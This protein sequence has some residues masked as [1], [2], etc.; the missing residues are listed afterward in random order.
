[1]YEILGKQVVG[2]DIKRI[3]IKAPAIVKNGKLGQFVVIMP[4]EKSSRFALPIVEINK[5]KES[6][7]LVFKED[8][9][10]AKKLG[11]MWLADSVHSILGP[12][13]KPIEEE[14]VGTVLCIGYELGITQV[15]SACRALKTSGNK[16]IGVLG[17]KTKKNLCLEAQMHL[18]CQKV[19]V[20][21]EDGSTGKRE[22]VT[23]ILQQL[24][25]KEKINLIYVA[26]PLGVMQEV[27]AISR[28]KKVK[29]KIL[30]N[31]MTIDGFGIS[32]SDQILVDGKYCHVSVDGPCFDASK[33]DFKS[34]EVRIKNFRE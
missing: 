33:V 29:T 21:T 1:M 20:T 5:Q 15:I 34:L 7:T 9:L 32:D 14:Q 6:I 8:T 30:L 31:P 13:G 2:N 26:A 10:S 12:L 17:A 3:T 19:F 18:A 22:Y 24:L 11:D 4:D 23:D 27:L 28:D 16:V 25:D